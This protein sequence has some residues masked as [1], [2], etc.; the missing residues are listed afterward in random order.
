M[1][2]GSRSTWRRRRRFRRRASSTPN[3][4]GCGDRDDRLRGRRRQ[5]AGR[6]R[7]VVDGDQLGAS[8]IRCGRGRRGGR[9]AC[10]CAALQVAGR[11]QLAAAARRR[12]DDGVLDGV[13]VDGFARHTAV[14]LV[15]AV[16]ASEMTA[17]RASCS[18]CAPGGVA[19]G[20]SDDDVPGSGPSHA[21]AVRGPPL[22]RSTSRVRLPAPPGPQPVAEQLVVGAERQRHTVADHGR[23]GRD[24]DLRQ[25]QP[26][27]GG[28]E[29][30]L[31]RPRRPGRCAAR[32]HS[33]HHGGS[34]LDEQRRRGR[35]DILLQRGGEV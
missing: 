21:V 27:V 5:R 8:L 24:R 2:A 9:T 3:C 1:R 17:L 28:A 6:A 10:A 32:P 31:T 4:A 23:D 20:V 19:V 15:Y 33:L 7:G 13:V 25:V 34:A 18:S 11:V 22:R 16:A 29:Q 14:G 12:A 26:R 35:I 30:R